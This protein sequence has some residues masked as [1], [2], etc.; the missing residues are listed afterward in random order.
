M[1][2]AAIWAFQEDDKAPI[3]TSEEARAASRPLV[4]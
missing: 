2:K 4:T 3:L 1:R